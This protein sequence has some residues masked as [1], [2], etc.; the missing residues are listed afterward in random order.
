LT[1]IGR[2]PH[3]QALPGREHIMGDPLTESRGLRKEIG[4]LGFGAI[5]LNGTIGAGIFALPAY[6]IGRAGLF[7]PWIFMFCGLLI[8]L[9]VLVFARVASY[10]S[11]TGGPVTYTTEAFGPFAG[12]QTGWLLTLSRASA[13]AANAHLMITYAGWFWPPL[14]E[15]YA[16][17]AAVLAT[18]GLLTLI[19]AIG[20][21]QGMLAVFALTVLK[22]L[23][24]FLLLVL[25]AAQ[26]NPQVF[27]GADVPPLDSLGE[28]AL[29]MF[30]AFV[31]FET[32]VVPAGEGRNARRDIP[33]ALVWT[34]LGITLF[35]FLI[36]V[37]AVSVAPGIGVSQTPL[38]DIAQI[39]MGAAGAGIL[40]LG[41]VFSISGNLTSSMLSAPRMI[42]AMAHLGSLPG[43][44]GAV[45][46][47]FQT[48][49]NAIAFYGAFAALLAL[50]G[51]F[52]WLAAMSTVVR[53][54]VYV[55][56]IATLPR[57]QRTRG[58]YEGQF[59][60]PGGYAIPA[61]ALVLSLW[62]MTHADARSWLLTAGFMA[63][64]GV[65][66]LLAV[67]LGAPDSGN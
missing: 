51:G 67:R 25:G 40:T 61:S 60:L 11:V 43:W 44:F 57:L 18:C 42:Y 13:F 59:R 26:I 46:S 10:F 41:A 50:T 30:Y 19:N 6:A 29:V 15:G 24:L 54:L 20:I 16:H 34:I 28:T 27:T 48:P 23:P 1:A 39:L 4:R 2:R 17:M 21:R 32:A 62:L 58:E 64:G 49:A 66:Y 36:Q 9:I 3:D 45:H 22:L 5:A 63:A 8:M 37:V 53:L 55:A 31:G 12:F 38:A 65:L 56:C 35:Y 7:S 33:S 47:R 14:A 52:V